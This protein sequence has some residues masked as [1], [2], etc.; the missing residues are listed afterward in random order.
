MRA[1][2]QF[3]ILPG[4]AH[5]MTSHA[6]PSESVITA[7][8]E[9]GAVIVHLGRGRLFA[10]NHTG[11]E[12][13]RKLEARLSL[14]AIARDLTHEYRLPPDVAWAQTTQFVAALERERLVERRFQ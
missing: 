6:V 8:H 3:P 5:D 4:G 10:S 13:W 1:L 12:I 14:D 9:G 11:L 7:E 2:K